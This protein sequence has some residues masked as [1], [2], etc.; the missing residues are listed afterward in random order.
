MMFNNGG[1]NRLQKKL[2]FLFLGLVMGVFFST[3]VL[4]F[5]VSLTAQGS[6]KNDTTSPVGA[7][8]WLVEEDTTHPVTPGVSD[9]T[10]LSFS[11]HKSHAPVVITGDQSNANAI[12]LPDG[13]RYFVSVLPN[14]GYTIGGAQI[15][16]GQGS[17]TVICNELPLPTAQISVLVY[18]DNFPLNNAPDAP[19]VGLAGFKITVEDAGGRWGVSAG[20]QMMDAFGNMIGTTYQTTNGVVDLDPDGN[21]IVQTLGQGFVLTDAQG[22]ALIKYMGPAKYGIQ[23]IPPA[24]QGWQQTSTIEGTRIID[25][26]VK[27]DEPPFFTEFG[28]AGQHVAIGFIQETN[29]I[30]PAGESRDISGQVVNMRMARPPTIEF[31]PGEPHANVWVGLNA[32]ATGKGQALYAAPA[33]VSTGEFTIPNVPPG[34]YQ[35]VFW[36]RYLN[37]IFGFQG[38]VV[39][40]GGGTIDLG[41]VPVFRWFGKMENTVFYDDNEN[42][43]REPNETY[44]ILEQAINLRFRD[45]SLYQILP[46]DNSGEAP[47]EEVFPFFHWLVAEVDFLRFKA[48][49]MSVIVDGGGP[50]DPGSDIHA[51]AQDPNDPFNELASSTSRT[52]SGPVL[53]QGM[54]L[55]LGQTNKFEWGKKDYATGENG[56]ISGIVY[57]SNTRAEDDPRYGVGEPWEP[58]VPR[59]QVNLYADG[60]ATNDPLGALPDGIIDDLDG[61]DQV[62]LAD[63]DNYPFQW[64]PVYQGQLGWTGVPGPEDVDRG[65]DGT[66]DYGDAIQIATTDSWDD[67]EPTGC[68]GDPDDPFYDINGDGI[69]D[70]YDGLR[71]FNQVRPGLFDGGYAFTSYYPGGMAAPGSTEVDGLPAASYIVE[72]V[73]PPAY[74]LVKEEDRN[75]DFGDSYTPSLQLL[76]PVCVGDDHTVPAEL[77]LF[78]GVPAAFAGQVRP[79]CDRKQ[80]PLYQG[81]NAAADFFLF[82]KVPKAA[83]IVGFVLNDLANEFNPLTPNFGEKYAPPWLP[84]SI[85]DYRGIEIGKVYTDEFGAYNAL[86]P[87][88]FTANR[89]TPSGFSPNMLTVVINDNTDSR[90]NPLYTSFQYTFQYM[91]GVTTY[92]DTPVLPIAAFGA[93]NVRPVDAEFPDGTPVISNVDGDAAGPY[94]AAAGNTITITSAGT[95]VR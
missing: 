71:N 4:A 34:G 30:P 73:P 11:F 57:Y 45:G 64:A 9:F 24:G 59:V 2:L 17:V 42:G 67:N 91:P 23:A 72:V 19:E 89:P 83:R 27:P 75:V 32:G 95:A 85:R 6:N 36:D 51:Q 77:D 90:Y 53:T 39:P 70:C 92:L 88:T 82:T 52:E 25:A 13:K 18:Q 12:T 10:S 14:A 21:P 65:N 94:V 56:G 69:G 62:T 80:T 16:D 20:Q 5:S 28:P 84:V 48:T 7:F 38:I 3:S 81:S 58:G 26:W 55:F 78:P 15:A 87:S 22:M 47:L 86:A 66:F 43:F 44:G 68:P 50:V 79:L 93:P 29:V 1:V 54:Q 41:Q 31:G 49:G 74:E 40:P 37:N 60:G 61:D 8:R 46:T 76:P 35:L 33:N 63:A